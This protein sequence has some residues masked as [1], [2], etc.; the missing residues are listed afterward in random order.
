MRNGLSEAVKAVRDEAVALRHELH[1]HPE[2]RFEEQWTS[3]R[4]ARFLT[5]NG[6]AFRRGFAKGT[7]IVAE[8]PGEAGAGPR[9]ALRA[10]MDALEI[11]EETGLP[12]AS[13]I[14]GRM[15]ACGHDGHMA[16][17]CGAAKVLHGMRTQLPGSVR[18]LF[19]PGEELAA[20][21]S[22]M[23]EEGAMEGV[24]AVFGL[25]GWP[26]MRCGAVGLKPGPMMASAGD[27]RIEVIGKGC[28]AA[29]AYEGID[30]IV[31]A[32]SIT[33]ALQ[34]IVGREV[35]AVEPAV[36]TVAEIKGGTTTNIIPE[37]ATLRGT[38]RSLSEAVDATLRNGIE[39]VA[40]GVAAAH[41]ARAEVT[42]GE[43]PYPPTI[44]DTRM[45]ALAR[46]VAVDCLGPGQV[47]DIPE[48]TMGAEDFAYY[49]REAPGSYLWL[50]VNPSDSEP[51]PSLHNAKYDFTDDAV[52]VG[53]ELMASTA[54]AFLASGGERG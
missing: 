1:Q 32:A 47:V 4:I 16:M 9:V 30:P 17:I 20:G 38:F 27:F 29:M 49:L 48:P 42:F 22:Y 36:L 14:P 41:G 25:H 33:T 26:G 11:Q 23:V 53:I 40:H 51:Y 15:H 13:T 31:V 52:P 21:A 45:T 28:H 39:R 35:P 43:R 44:N 2:I 34:A 54:V 24:D 7:G 19:Q 3:D 8:I 18:I 46:Q 12:Y 37:R 6:I 5:E 50:G 10:D